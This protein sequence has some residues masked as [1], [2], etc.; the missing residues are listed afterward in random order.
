MVGSWTVHLEKIAQIFSVLQSY[1]V[2]TLKENQQKYS[3]VLL[4]L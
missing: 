1:I 2:F 3:L 4:V